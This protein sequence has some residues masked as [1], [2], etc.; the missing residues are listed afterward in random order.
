MNEHVDDVIAAYA[1]DAL[2]RAERQ[3][4]EAH[5]RTCAQCRAEA[6]AARAVVDVLP[7]ALEP[8][9]PSAGLR[10]RILMEARRDAAPVRI[11]PRSEEPNRWA[12]FGRRVLQRRIAFSPAAGLAAAVLVLAIGF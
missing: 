6:G 3:E 11:V 1:L 8:V 5:L 10:E 7:L 2:P 9:Q 12:T 4:V